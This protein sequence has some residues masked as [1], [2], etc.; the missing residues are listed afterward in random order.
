MFLFILFYF[1]LIFIFFLRDTTRPDRHRRRRL[2]RALLDP[3][4]HGAGFRGFPA[5]PVGGYHRDEGGK[6]T[7]E[8]GR[9]PLLELRHLEALG[10]PLNTLLLSRRTSLL[11]DLEESTP[12]PVGCS[13][14]YAPVW[15][16]VQSNPSSPPRAN[17][18]GRPAHLGPRPQPG[19]RPAR[20]L[21]PHA[22]TGPDP[23][24]SDPESASRGSA[25]RRPRPNSFAPSVHAT[26][27]WRTLCAGSARCW[28][29]TSPQPRV[30]PGPHTVNSEPCG[31]C[32][33]RCVR[34]EFVL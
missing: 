34:N 29:R 21:R 1:I 7:S 18:S 4:V 26:E 2:R 28:T 8:V 17:G 31:C 6:E 12:P 27:H 15:K 5:P 16:V 23:H 19:P 30:P 24:F 22:F 25:W 10:T 3:E 32:A 11:E 20:W 14:R 13:E 33:A 9:A